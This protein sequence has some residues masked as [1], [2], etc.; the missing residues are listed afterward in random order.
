MWLLGIELRTLGRAG[1]ALNHRAISPAQN[2]LFLCEHCGC[3]D[4]D[5]AVNS[6]LFS[7]DFFILLLGK[8]NIDHR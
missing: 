5:V 6:K 4:I 2:I 3:L 8:K 1:N 7:W